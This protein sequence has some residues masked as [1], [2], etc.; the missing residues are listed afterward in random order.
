MIFFVNVYNSIHKKKSCPFPPSHIMIIVWFDYISI[1]FDHL[2]FA[3]A[4]LH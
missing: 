1:T 3:S 4:L 2:K